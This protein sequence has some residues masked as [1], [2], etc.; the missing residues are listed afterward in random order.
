MESY[1]PSPSI[2]NDECDG[3]QEAIKAHA[4]SNA[5]DPLKR[6]DIAGQGKG[7]GGLYL[8]SAVAIL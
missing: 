7:V 1:F 8:H 2:W 3:C 4:A 5:I 6:W